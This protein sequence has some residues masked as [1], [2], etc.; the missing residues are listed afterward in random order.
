M[1]HYKKYWSYN[2]DMTFGTHSLS[3]ERPICLSFDYQGKKFLSMTNEFYQAGRALHA[4]TIFIYI[5]RIVTLFYSQLPEILKS[6][7]LLQ[8]ENE[9]PCFDP[10]DVI[11]ITNKWDTIQNKDKDEDS[12][13]DDEETKVWE[14]IKSNVKQRWLSV[15][16]ENIFKMNLTEVILLIFFI[17]ISF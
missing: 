13:D 3:S 15:R 6:I 11:F 14:N 16:E 7:S 8:M 10:K 5:I 1:K 2:S 4:Y 12:S 9:M 17:L